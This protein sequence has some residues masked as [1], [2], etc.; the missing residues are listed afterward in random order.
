MGW[1][2]CGW[3]TDKSSKSFFSKKMGLKFL[4]FLTSTLS[5]KIRE[6]LLV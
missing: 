3:D 6:S 1:N 4:N 2:D 5:E